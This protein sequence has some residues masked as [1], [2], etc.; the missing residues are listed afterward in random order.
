MK[1]LKIGNK[2]PKPIEPPKY[3]KKCPE[4]GSVLEYTD[5]DTFLLGNGCEDDYVTCPVCQRD[6]CVEP[7]SYGRFM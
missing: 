2:R 3:K 1:V 4:C 7:K 5:S 6:I